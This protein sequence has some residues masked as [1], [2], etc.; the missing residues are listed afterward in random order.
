MRVCVPAMHMLSLISRTFIYLYV[1]VYD[2]MYRLHT[3]ARLVLPVPGGPCNSTNLRNMARA[4]ACVCESD[5]SS[6]KTNI[7]HVFS[8]AANNRCGFVVKIF[9]NEID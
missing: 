3:L 9:P 8:S 6:L 5:V 7:A 2:N 4:G 1:V